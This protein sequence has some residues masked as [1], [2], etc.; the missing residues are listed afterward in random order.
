[1]NDIENV[2]FWGI[3]AIPVFYVLF[4]RRCAFRLRYIYAYEYGREDFSTDPSR[5]EELF[6]PVKVTWCFFLLYGF[7]HLTN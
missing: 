3:Y 4:I 5:F 7:T 6:H 2:H 1:M